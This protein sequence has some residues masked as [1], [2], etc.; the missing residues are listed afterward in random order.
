MVMQRMP[1]IRPAHPEEAAQI[2]ELALRSKSHWD[3]AP[4]QLE[5]FREELT[6]TPETIRPHRTHVLLDRRRPRFPRLLIS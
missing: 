5:V 1:F 4:E 6:L 2:S 3:Y